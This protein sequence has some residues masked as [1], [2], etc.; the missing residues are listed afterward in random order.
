[1]LITAPRQ[2]SLVLGPA[3]MLLSSPLPHVPP[4]LLLPRRPTSPL[5]VVLRLIALRQ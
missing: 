3:P 2:N 4:L 1:M 5:A